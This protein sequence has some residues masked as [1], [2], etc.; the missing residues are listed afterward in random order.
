MVGNLSWECRNLRAREFGHANEMIHVA[1]RLSNVF[2]NFPF[3]IYKLEKHNCICCAMSFLVYTALRKPNLIYPAHAFCMKAQDKIES[4]VSV[5]V[6]Q[7]YW[8]NVF[9]A[10]C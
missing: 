4:A 9:E 6:V 7:F 1:V 10:Q 3:T 8:L 5:S 2:E